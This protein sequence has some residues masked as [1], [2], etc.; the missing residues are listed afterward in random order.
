MW[1]TGSH[2]LEISGPLDLRNQNQIEAWCA[3]LNV[4]QEQLR[5]YVVAVGPNFAAVEYRA[6]SSLRKP[7]LVIANEGDV[8]RTT[9]SRWSRGR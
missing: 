3:R 9:G 7:N 2:A 6:R 8:V 4:T 5:D 1:T